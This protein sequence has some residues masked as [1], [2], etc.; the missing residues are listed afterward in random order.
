MNWDGFRYFV[1]LARAGSLSAAAR[2]LGVDHT[3]VA[4]RIGQLEARLE[5][6]LFDR[7]A[8]GWLPTA[9][10]LQ[11]IDQVETIETAFDEIAMRARIGGG[12]IGGTV[13][14]TA[15]P[16]LAGIWLAPQLGRIVANFPELCIDLNAESHVA[17]LARRE[18]DIA[19]RL[20]RPEGGTIVIR[21]LPDFNYGLYAHHDYL[22]RYPPQQWSFIGFGHSLVNFPHAKWLSDYIS[23]RS[24]IF[25]SD[26]TAALWSAARAGLGL[27]LLP[28]YIAAEQPELIC[29]EA[30]DQR[31]TRELWLVAHRDI[32][33]APAVRV[34]LDRL[35]ALFKDARRTFE[36]PPRPISNNG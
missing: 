18:A 2:K 5:Q 26:D 17:Q 10:A 29:V 4:R 24:V 14:I 1:E 15:P 9:E 28:H 3:T 30:G 12:T 19:I 7:L 6:R 36:H 11:M 20:G 16:T 25:T 31:L 23:G 27:A 21:R 22:D 35:A 8:N 34:V 13:Q 33:R 32:R